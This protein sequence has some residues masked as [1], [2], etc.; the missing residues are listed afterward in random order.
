MLD[1]YYESFCSEVC[2]SDMIYDKCAATFDIRNWLKISGFKHTHLV[3]FIYLPRWFCVLEPFQ[4]A[5]FV[6]M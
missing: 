5:A 1:F 4:S 3:V 2:F 6:H